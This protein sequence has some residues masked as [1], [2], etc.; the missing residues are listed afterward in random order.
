MAI[1][2]RAKELG[3]SAEEHDK[4][5]GAVDTLAFLT[6]ELEIKGA[7]VRKLRRMLFGPGSEKTSVVLG[8]ES[9]EQDNEE[10]NQDAEPPSTEDSPTGDDSDSPT[11]QEEKPT[12][13][14][15]GRNGAAS[16]RGAEKVELSHGTLE[17]RDPCPSCEQGKVY[18]QTTPAVM[19][20]V[21]GMAPLSATVYERERL[22]CNL[23]GEVFT[24]KSP[25]GVGE[26]KYDE[27]AIAMIAL[28]KYGSGVP[29]Y[30][31]ERLEGSLGIP[32]PSSTQ[33]DLVNGASDL[34][35]PAHEELIRQAAQGAVLHNDDT[36]M[37][38]LEIEPMRSEHKD[39][40][41]TD[42]SGSRT[43]GIVALGEGHRIALFFTG[44][45]H[46]GENLAD[47]L[48]RRSERAKAPIQMCDALS[49]NAPGDFATILA[50]CLAHARRKFV[51][52]AD[53]F[54]E[55]CRLVLEA[56]R[57]VYRFD[58]EARERDLD[59]QQRLLFHRQHSEPLMDELKIWLDEQIEL[60][61]VESNS[62]LG[63]AIGYMTKHWAKL[64]LF[65]REA[66]APLDNN[67]CERILKRAILHR[68]NS[69]FYK[70]A[71]GA[72]VGDR[73]MAMIHTAELNQVNPFD[74]LLALL[75]RHQEVGRDPGAWMPWNFREALQE[76]TADSAVA[77]S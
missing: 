45:Q 54:P 7:S 48:A 10:G 50:N 29:F 37:K 39:K 46:A 58:A 32:L 34:L 63:Q 8:E 35:E 44:V 42:R 28:L 69:M 65:L 49:H 16:F 43:S 25:G 27:S 74:Y 20:R 52:V 33:W 71:N 19:V 17:H 55:D 72:R 24:A 12:P 1:L 4:L 23:C 36:T 40:G 18:R 59:D 66:G 76:A 5:V 3:L 15:H 51:D 57:E 75:R 73:F 22:R 6:A 11:G 77:V 62:G 13:R 41:G 67:I 68:K 30:R 9:S 2:A 56:L 64:T 14:G 38:I 47:V 60:K 31:L 61:K 53:N 70:T 21:R 26:A